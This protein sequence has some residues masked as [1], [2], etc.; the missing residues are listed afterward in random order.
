MS[1]IAS[2]QHV[3]N[4]AK[5]HIHTITSKS[6][7]SSRWPAVERQW[8]K[9]HPKCA[10]CGS[11]IR[12]QVHHKQPFHLYPALE[13]DETNLISL[14]MDKLDCHLLIGHGGSFKAFVPSV[15]VLAAQLRASPATRDAVVYAAKVSRKF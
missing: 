1:L 10:A 6:K 5:H 15:A 12:V 2:I 13:L 11:E 3:V 9:E 7:R 8:K 4:L 14:C